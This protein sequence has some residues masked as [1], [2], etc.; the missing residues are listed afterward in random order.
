MASHSDD[1]AFVADLKSATTRGPAAWANAL[2][3]TIV[4]FFVASISWMAW[5]SL[6]EVTNA[7]GRVIPPSQTQIVQN[8]EGGILAEILI[9]EGQLVEPNQ[10]LLRIDDTNFSSSLRENTG[11]YVALLAKTVR[12]EAEVANAEPA[13]PAELDE[14]PQIV[15]NESALHRARFSELQSAMAVLRGQEDQRKQEL[16]ELKARVGKLGESLDLAREEFGILE[17]MVAKGVTSRIELLR[18]RRQ[19]TELEREREAAEL[20]MPRARSALAEYARRMEEKRAT[21]TSAAQAELNDTRVRLSALKESLAAVEDRVARTEVRSPVRG[22]IKQLKINT[23]G[24]V[25]QPGMDLVEIVP[26]EDNLLVEASIRPSDI[27]F[28]HPG[29]NVKVKITAYDFARYGALDGK[30]EHISADTIVDETG[31][32]F[33]QIRVRT[34]KSHLGGDD[35]PLPIIPGMIAEVDILTGKKTVLDYLLKPVLQARERAMRER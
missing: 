32:S 25:I 30:L 22:T 27:A 6:D 1:S 31:E 9:T 14:H 26:L 21:F 34:D 12:L 16:V 29:Q 19:V 10:V 28:L 7:I 15:A 4:L 11:R 8:L 33:Y 17:P 3:I 13:F 2:F 24:G 5:A 20:S 18:L 35:D 23:V